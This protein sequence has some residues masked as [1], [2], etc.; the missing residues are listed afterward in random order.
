VQSFSLSNVSVG[1]TIRVRGYV[2]PT[3]S[4]MVVA[5][6]LE[7]VTPTTTVILQGPFAAATSPDFTV[8][9]ITINASSATIRAGDDVSLTLA[10]FLSQAVSHAVKVEGTLSG[11]VVLAATIRIDDENGDEN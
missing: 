11:A 3:G 10:Q 7:R 1:D 6:H 9:G 4:N 2:N 5:T 8:L